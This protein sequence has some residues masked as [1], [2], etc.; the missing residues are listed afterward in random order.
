MHLLTLFVKGFSTSFAGFLKSPGQGLHPRL[1]LDRWGRSSLPATLL[2]AGGSAL[3]CNECAGGLT[4]TAHQDLPSQAHSHQSHRQ[5]DGQCNQCSPL[6]PSGSTAREWV[7]L[8][9][10]RQVP[11]LHRGTP[12][13]TVPEGISWSPAKGRAPERASGNPQRASAARHIASGML[14]TGPPGLET[15]I[16]RWI[17]RQAGD[18]L[19]LGE[20]GQPS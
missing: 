2:L 10:P 14:P 18:P 19:Q 6:S 9:H 11:L 3:G 4:F 13:V 16:T 17:F 8:A 20:Q 7:P 5:M 1:E 15:G 12:P